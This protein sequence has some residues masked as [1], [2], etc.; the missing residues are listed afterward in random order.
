[1]Q[2]D[3]LKSLAADMEKAIDALR[4]DLSAVRTGRAAPGLIENVQVNVAS[5]GDTMPLKQLGNIAAPDARL[6]LVT[7]WDKTTIQDIEKGIAAAG[8]GL[9]PS[10]DGHVI[11]IP[12][13]ALTLERRQ[14][15]VKLVKKAG[16][17]A[18]VRVRNI[19]REYNEVFKELEAEKD[20]TE[21]ALKKLTEKV[22][23]S[24]D[25]H[26][27]KVDDVCAAKEKEVLEV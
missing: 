23:I 19:R 5:Y 22:Q 26:V 16:E 20:I 2:D 13:P 18:K 10:S 3:Y 1:M 8:L 11:R 17:E 9:N 12:I 15:L 25:Q 4:R 24:T 27:K 7:P 6:L 21:D 14:G